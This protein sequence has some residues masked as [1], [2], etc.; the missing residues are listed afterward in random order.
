[1]NYLIYFILSVLGAL[2]ALML[3]GGILYLL[4]QRFEDNF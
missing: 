1:M 3:F 2:A 4:E